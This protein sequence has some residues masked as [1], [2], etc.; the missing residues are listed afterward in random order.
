MRK[1]DRAVE[2]LH[3]LDFLLVHLAPSGNAG[4]VSQFASHGDKNAFLERAAEGRPLHA[5]EP[6]TCPRGAPRCA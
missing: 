3:E 5:E 6:G 4:F 2:H 1:R